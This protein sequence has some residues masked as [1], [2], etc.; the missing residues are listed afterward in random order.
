MT[1]K[2]LIVDDSQFFCRRVG[3]ILSSA[4]DIKVIGVA[5]NGQEAIDKAKQLKPDVITLDVEMPVMDGVTALKQIVK[6]CDAKVL[7][8]S[9][10]TYDN[11]KITLDA[12]D[13]GA[14][15]FLLKSYESLSND[16]D[17]LVTLLQSKIREL[18]GIK[19]PAPI[20]PNASRTSAPK[21]FP[22][23]K[24]KSVS[25]G[26]YNLLAIGASTGG[27]V[28]L[29]KLLVPLPQNFPCPITVT[30]HMPGT[31]TGAFAAR[32]NGLCQL[33]VCEAT[34]GMALKAGHVYIAPG[35]KQMVFEGTSHNARI[36]IR[37]ADPRIAFS[38]SVDLSFGSASKVFGGKIF[39]LV[40]TGMG[41][42]GTEGSKLIKAKGGKIWA[43]NEASCVVYGMPMSVT[44]AGLSD[45]ELALETMS[46]EIMKEI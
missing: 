14:T 12:L 36:R 21:K 19:R 15:D 27:P 8:L 29:Q 38:P 13:A 44:R 22:T 7:M 18:G 32:L 41:S 46:S 31:F 24:A 10:L 39:A 37:P 43:Q 34:D 2:V 25:S 11:A 1:I 45:R 23:Y 42:D 17:S 40:L 20:Q 30:Q 9:S 4:Q 16:S 28:A 3:S 6:I 26:K 5:H 33:T 35:G